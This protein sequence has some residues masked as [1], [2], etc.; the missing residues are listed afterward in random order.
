[1]KKGAFVFTLIVLIILAL[2]V[3]LSFLPVLIGEYHE[4]YIERLIF[5]IIMSVFLTFIY[6]LLKVLKK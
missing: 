2:S 1:M 4:P 3:F 5:G 6:L